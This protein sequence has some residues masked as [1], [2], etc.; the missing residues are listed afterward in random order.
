MM[1]HAYLNQVPS[2]L[3]AKI[4]RAW[5]AKETH[6]SLWANGDLLWQSSDGSP[7]D[8]QGATLTAPVLV[9][10]TAVAQLT[11]RGSHNPADERRLE[12]DAY[13]LGHCASLEYELETLTG[14][15]VETQDQLL[16][17]Y[18][19][20]RASRSHL[21]VPDTAHSV[22][23]EAARLVAVEATFVVLEAPPEWPIL[24][25]CHQ[26]CLLDQ[27]QM[28]A[29]FR[30]AQET[31]TEL[32]LQGAEAASLLG[33][34]VKNLL[35]APV[36]IQGQVWAGLG[37]LNKRVGKFQSPDLKLIQAIAE[38]VGAQIENALL[39][40]E[41]VRQARLQTEI[42]LAQDVQLQLLPNRLPH[43]AGL[44]LFACSRPARQV[45]GDFY[46]FIHAPDRPLIFNVGDVSGKGVSSAL[47]MT[48]VRTIIRS[49]GRFMHN[50]SPQALLERANRDLYDDFSEVMMFATVFVGQYEPQTRCL[51][52]ANAGHSPVI[53]C[54]AAGAPRLL[55]ADGA[56]VGVLPDSLA[57]NQRLT[58]NAGDLL[59]IASDGFNEAH[60][61]RGELFGLERLLALVGQLR[62][63]TAAEI[64]KTLYET[65]AEFAAEQEQA[66]DQTLI[67][68]KGVA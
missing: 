39:L 16:A 64:A 53:F 10:G 54:P 26:N 61:E 31:K 45:G 22:A 24:I 62:E 57:T 27:A 21:N 36:Q 48:M 6:I 8:S 55:E 29:L 23:A 56:P 40:H 25:A 14:D 30:Q 3:L 2:A 34:P 18:D 12:A 43:V 11:L 49:A 7:P 37:F 60:N 28:T 17:L 1:M 65:T 68:V 58:L 5:R 33:Q 63:K 13:L 19:L 9:A 47:L 51:T 15:L 20:T 44:D 41:T 59:V 52:Y 38:Q 50:P 32:L 4:G 67:V 35:L 46:D 42:K 66:D